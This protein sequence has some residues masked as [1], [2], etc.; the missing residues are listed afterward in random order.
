M[1]NTKLTYLDK[2]NLFIQTNSWLLY[3]LTLILLVLW[4][5]PGR[6]ILTSDEDR[7]WERVRRAEDFYL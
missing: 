1:K 2:N 5:I 3:I 7:L 6:T 4:F